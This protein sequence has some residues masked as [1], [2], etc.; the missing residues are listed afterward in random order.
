MKTYY[1]VK[2][3]VDGI[4]TA[5]LEIWREHNLFYIY[6]YDENVLTGSWGMM[7]RYVK[8]WVA[9]YEPLA[10]YL[11]DNHNA[12]VEIIDSRYKEVI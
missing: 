7:D 9:K 1:E 6:E 8:E 4:E 5:K 11:R 3:V 2:M 10:A 12:K